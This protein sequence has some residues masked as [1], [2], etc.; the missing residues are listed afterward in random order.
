MTTIDMDALFHQLNETRRHDFDEALWH[1]TNYDAP[2][3]SI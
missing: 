1:E 2:F 3:V